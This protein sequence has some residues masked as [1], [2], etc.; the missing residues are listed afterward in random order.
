MRPVWHGHI[1]HG[2]PFLCDGKRGPVSFRLLEVFELRDRKIAREQV[3][4][5]LVE[6]Q[7]QL[8]SG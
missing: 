7:R 6:I 3:W 4:C 5:D 8:E 1:N 2:R